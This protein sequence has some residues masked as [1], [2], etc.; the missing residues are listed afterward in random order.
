MSQGRIA[1]CYAGALQMTVTLYLTRHG[2]TDWNHEGRWQGHTDIALNEAGRVQARELAERLRGLGIGKVAASDL[3][4]ARETAQIVAQ[5]LGLEEVAVD[6]R[7]RER[8][9][10]A[11]EG[12][13]RKDV[14]ERYPQQWA[15]YQADKRMMPPGA[16]PHELVI[17]RM[18]GAVRT[19]LEGVKPDASVLIVSHGGA[20]RLLLTALTG[21]NIPPVPNAAVYK[22]SLLR[23]S[24]GPATLLAEP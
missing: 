16:E 9:F 11:F 4:R 19:A 2:E 6:A 5:A 8:S 22:L 23:G 3:G 13:T 7:L 15:D 1:K 20:L 12:L 21:Q 14:A 10:G 17:S 24:F 18:K